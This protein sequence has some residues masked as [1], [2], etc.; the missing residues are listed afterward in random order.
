MDRQ[1]QEKFQTILPSQPLEDDGNEWVTADSQ[2]R[3]Q[4]KMRH[5][6][7]TTPAEEVSGKFNEMPPAYELHNENEILRQI[8]GCTDFSYD[9]TPESF[10][11]GYM[12]RPMNGTDDQ[13]TGEHADHFYG[14]AVDV[15]E[16]SKVGF[17]ERNNYLDRL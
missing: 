14:E 12:R 8:A 1:L 4:E 3:V 13:Y 11:E 17:V 10:H 5:R 16:P 7:N 6:N 15:E 9:T 2:R